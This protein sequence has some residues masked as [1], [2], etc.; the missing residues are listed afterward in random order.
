M[1]MRQRKRAKHC[2]S[3]TTISI[4]KFDA[5]VSQQGNRIDDV[6]NE[7]DTSAESREPQVK[8]LSRSC[9]ASYIDDHWRVVEMCSRETAQCEPTIGW[10]VVV[11]LPFLVQ[12]VSWM[13]KHR[14]V[15]CAMMMPGLGR[16]IVFVARMLV[17][18]P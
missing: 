16:A 14:Q 5:R 10:V 18:L 3:L 8:E 17:M 4:I 11:R 12:D 1:E 2:P 15:E 13:L 9:N 7:R 6:H